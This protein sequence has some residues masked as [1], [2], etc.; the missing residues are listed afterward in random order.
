MTG[1]GCLNL[2]LIELFERFTVVDVCFPPYVENMVGHSS[3]L[4]AL[5]PK[6]ETSLLILSIER[7]KY[8]A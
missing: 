7:V 8:F 1:R 3:H 2:A 5:E 6:S 4:K